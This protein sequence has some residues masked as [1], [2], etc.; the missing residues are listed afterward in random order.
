[1]NIKLET[2]KNLEI[3]NLETYPLTWK[4]RISIWKQLFVSIKIRWFP[5]SW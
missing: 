2:H 3:Y 4:H 5:T 1:M